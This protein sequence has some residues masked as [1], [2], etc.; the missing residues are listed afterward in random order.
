MFVIKSKSFL[1]RITSYALLLPCS[2]CISLGYRKI[3]NVN[4]QKWRLWYY[5]HIHSCNSD[6]YISPWSA[7]HNRSITALF[8]HSSIYSV[9]KLFTHSLYGA[10]QCTV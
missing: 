8:T 1:N 6:L 3:S 5:R 10:C 9:T 2:L 7:W 4:N